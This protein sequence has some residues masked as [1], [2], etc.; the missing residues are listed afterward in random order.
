MIHKA[1]VQEAHSTGSIQSIFWVLG[2]ALAFTLAMS[3]NK[4]LPSKIDSLLILFM[5][6]ALGFFFFMLFFK[7]TF[8]GS[9]RTER[10]PLHLLRVSFA[11]GA[12]GC[13]YYVYRHVD[14]TLATTVGFICPLITSFLG[15]VILKEQLSWQQWILLIVGYGGI[16]LA[17][18]PQM[19]ISFGVIVS[20]IG[21]SL[22]A[23]SIIC[24]KR[25]TKTESSATL[26][27]YMNVAT[28]LLSG[29]TL[30]SVY[31]MRDGFDLSFWSVLEPLDFLKLC[32][33]GLFGLASQYCYMNAIRLS[34]VGF[35]APFEYLRLVLSI[36]AGYLI[37]GEIPTFS[38]IAGATLIVF[39]TVLI[40]RQGI[41]R[42]GKA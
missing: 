18:Q 24:M 7:G 35:V 25:L 14:M 42:E 8:K 3:L 33:I 16:I 15:W 6:C 36:P 2:W 26:L 40:G 19:G 30:H 21:N 29:V 23:A 13:T 27:F 41:H 38:M 9:F 17:I 39:S 5:R 22:G 20:L 11:V 37:A 10:F 32:F 4:T 1:P 31:F 28:F 34:N 12:M